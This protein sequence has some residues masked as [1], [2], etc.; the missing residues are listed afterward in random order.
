MTIKL[1]TFE[2]L[3]VENLFKIFKF[4]SSSRACYLGPNKSES[5]PKI[6]EFY[7]EFGSNIKA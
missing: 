2:I 6:I 7:L 3:V 4:N 1:F 5:F